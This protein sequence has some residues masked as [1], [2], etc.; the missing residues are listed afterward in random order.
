MMHVGDAYPLKSPPWVDPPPV[1]L[2]TLSAEL[3]AHVLADVTGVPV[4]ARKAGRRAEERRRELAGPD[5]VFAAWTLLTTP[6][7]KRARRDETS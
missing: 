3:Q 1:F 5:A 7:T 6:L 2:P 4:S